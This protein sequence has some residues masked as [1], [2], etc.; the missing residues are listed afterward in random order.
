MTNVVLTKPIDWINFGSK[1]PSPDT[2][3]ADDS[4]CKGV[5]LQRKSDI[6][7]Y[8]SNRS[9]HTNETILFGLRHLTEK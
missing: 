3:L 6:P 5:C 7:Q 8:M 9:P 4:G 2:M 1:N